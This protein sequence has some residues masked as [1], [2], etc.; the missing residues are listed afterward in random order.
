MLAMG[1]CGDSETSAAT[2]RRADSSTS[3][4]ACQSADNGSCRSAY[5]RTHSRLL[6][7]RFPGFFVQTA[8]DGIAVAMVFEP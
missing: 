4:P 3:S 2:C 1:Q 7:A 5:A 8:L 6:A